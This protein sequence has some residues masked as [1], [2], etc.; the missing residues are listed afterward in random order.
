[1][2]CS[3]L[4]THVTRRTW[5]YVSKIKH[6]RGEIMCDINSRFPYINSNP[7][8]KYNNNGSMCDLSAP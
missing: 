4:N 2:P 6:E 8:T 7:S 1:M 5:E 3:R